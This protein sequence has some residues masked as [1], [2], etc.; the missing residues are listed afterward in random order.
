MAKKSRTYIWQFV[1]SLG[2]LSGI[3]TAIGLDPQEVILNALGNVAG[4][5]YPDPNVQYLF[6]ILPTILLSLSIIGAYTRGRLLGLVSV[7][8]AYLAGLSILVS[9]WTALVLLIIAVVIGYLAT[10]RR[11]VKKVTGI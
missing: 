8:V 2:F 9:F 10:N 3:W 11:L 6:I 4:T 5:V 7:I 1:I